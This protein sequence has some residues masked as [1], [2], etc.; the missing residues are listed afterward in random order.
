MSQRQKTIEVLSEE[1]S[2]LRDI[3]NALGFL[4]PQLGDNFPKNIK[5]LVAEM[6][7]E[8]HQIAETLENLIQ[9]LES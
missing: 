3:G 5:D 2:K 6:N 9:E 1:S 7:N 8:V 4:Y